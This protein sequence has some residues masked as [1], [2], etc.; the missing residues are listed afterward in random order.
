MWLIAGTGKTI[1]ASPFPHYSFPAIENTSSHIPHECVGLGLRVP[2]PLPFCPLLHVDTDHAWSSWKQCASVSQEKWPAPRLAARTE[3]SGCWRKRGPHSEAG[4][5]RLRSSS[6]TSS[7][8]WSL[9]WPILFLFCLG[10]CF[11]KFLIWSPTS[12]LPQ[13]VS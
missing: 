3:D 2:N 4:T 12:L 8:A 9:A 5:P 13:S 7:E 1:T 6:S 11:F 10:V